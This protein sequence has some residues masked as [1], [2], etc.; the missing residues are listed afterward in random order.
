M[1][2]NKTTPIKK[3]TKKKVLYITFS[4]DEKSQVME[5]DELQF[6]AVNFL[7][8]EEEALEDIDDHNEYHSIMKVT[9]EY[10]K[11]DVRIKSP[12]NLI[13]FELK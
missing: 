10:S 2:T 9:V 4:S 6:S 11:T 3:S 7:K 12:E 5:I 1:E 8:T 13:S